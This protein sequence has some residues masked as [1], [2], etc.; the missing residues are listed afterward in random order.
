MAKVIETS[1][2]KV[3]GISK[4]GCLEYLG[5]PYAKAP[6]GDLAFRRPEDPE[7]WDD[8]K[9]AD[10]GGRNSIQGYSSRHYISYNGQDCL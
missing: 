2:G 10:K 8:I 4:N 1:Y 9:T 6:V 7:P 5:I 3:S